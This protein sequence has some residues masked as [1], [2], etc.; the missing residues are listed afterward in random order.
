LDCENIKE[1]NR[2][3]DNCLHNNS[4]LEN[5]NLVPT[6]DQFVNRHIDTSSKNE[7]FP[8][9]SF[10]EDQPITQSKMADLCL[11]NIRSSLQKK[12][13]SSEIINLIEKATNE[14]SNNIVGLAIKK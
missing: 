1:S 12:K 14:S 11:S 7:P 8:D 13:F 6:I 10:T 9:M 4:I 5:S 3:T 2:R